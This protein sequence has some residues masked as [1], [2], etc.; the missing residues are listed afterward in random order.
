[1]TQQASRCFYQDNRSTAAFYSIKCTAECDSVE[2]K[3]RI[4]PLLYSGLV[5]RRLAGVNAQLQNSKHVR[6]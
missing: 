4:R 1:M 2:S 6:S 3:H 5:N